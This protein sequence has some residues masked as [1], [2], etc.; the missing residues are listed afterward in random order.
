MAGCLMD[1]VDRVVVT[2]VEDGVMLFSV[3][4]PSNERLGGAQHTYELWRGKECIAACESMQ[5][6]FDHLQ[7]PDEST[8]D[9]AK[10]GGS[11]A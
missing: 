11:T 3:L 10:D 4:R 2:Q 5:D 6:M 8:R 9:R 7:M 1:E